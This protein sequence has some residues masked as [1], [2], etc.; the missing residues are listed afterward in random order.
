MSQLKNDK[1]FTPSN[2]YSWGFASLGDLESWGR[3]HSSQRAAVGALMQSA[4]SMPGIEEVKAWHA[5]SERFDNLATPG[6][7]FELLMDFGVA[8]NAQLVDLAVAS[9]L[10]SEGYL[11]KMREHIGA[12]D[13]SGVTEAS[14]NDQAKE[15]KATGLLPD[16]GP[17]A[18][19]F[20]SGL[21]LG[22]LAVGARG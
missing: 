22:V 15:Q 20:S 1:G 8:S 17:E 9:A 5:E 19:T 3:L 13:T 12:S 6:L 10:N 18:G 2:P 4:G 21:V 14:K 16:S 7:G 11:S